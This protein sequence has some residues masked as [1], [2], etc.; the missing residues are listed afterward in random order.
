MTETLSNGSVQAESAETPLKVFISYR[1]ADTSSAA[2]LLYKDLEP[3][4]GR[5]NL[6]FDVEVLKPGMN[7][8]QAIRA[9]A[10]SCG[11]LLVLIGP[12]WLE[13]L[14]E[15]SG[16][17][18]VE[19]AD[20]VAR[21][22]IEYG[23]TNMVDVKVVPVLV[24]GASMPPRN[25]LPGSIKALA[26]QQGQALRED[27]Y[28]ED[29]KRL[30]EELRRIASEAPPAA[31]P[32]PEGP[33][34]I[35]DRH[36]RRYRTVAQKIV[37]GGRFVV[38][39]GSG[40]NVGCGNLPDANKLAVELARQY[41]YPIR[42]TGDRV[43]LTEVAEYVAVVEGPDILYGALQN[44]LSVD[45]D[46]SNVHRFLA[47]L[48]SVTERLGYP[49]QHQLIVTTNYD[50]LLE[51]AFR[52]AE[53]PFD[54]AVYVASGDDKGKFVHIPVEGS[55]ER[56]E[57]TNSYDKFPFHDDGELWRTLIVKIHG[58]VTTHDTAHVWR[59]NF[60]VTEDNYIDYLS[61][62]EMSELVPVAILERLRRS[63][64]LFLGYDI[65]EW[66]LRVFLKRV[67]GAQ[68]RN[69]SWTVQES[70]DELE[71]RLWKQAGI[72]LIDEPVE[73]YI[74]GLSACLMPDQ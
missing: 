39:L 9:S 40:V 71:E 44:H 23:L 48:P 24:E 52:E 10:N 46:V 7:W 73:Q 68:I 64:C 66:S 54:L 70:P 41:D 19:E 74:E 2:R 14:H 37:R 5:E 4:I 59:D 8:R 28:D 21:K 22:E 25:E 61:G 65:R 6:F 18:A 42:A 62:G 49:R 67:W 60:V 20:D 51:Q 57:P 35:P 16:L 47:T 27:T 36:P 34:Q 50:T 31:P 43:D 56:A 55:P 32:T 3:L 45:C 11:V 1:K 29:V 12:R 53:E 38:V 26:D 69:V 17:T 33:L 63:H 15:R 13:A 30:V 58:A 72:E